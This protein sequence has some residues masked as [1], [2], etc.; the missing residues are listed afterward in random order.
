MNFSDLV[1]SLL[2]LLW[3][4]LRAEA[5]PT[6]LPAICSSC[7][8]LQESR[9]ED[10]R[11][12]RQRKVGKGE[13]EKR[14]GRNGDGKRRGERDTVNNRPERGRQDRN[15]YSSVWASV[16][17]TSLT[18]DTRYLNC[19]VHPHTHTHKPHGV[20][21]YIYIYIYTHTH[22]HTQ[23]YFHSAFILGICLV[24]LH[25]NQQ[26]QIIYET[27]TH[28][29]CVCV[30]IFLCACVIGVIISWCAYKQMCQTNKWDCW[31]SWLLRISFCAIPSVLP[32]LLHSFKSHSPRPSTFPLSPSAPTLCALKDP[33][34]ERWN[35]PLFLPL[36]LLP[37]PFLLFLLPDVREGQRESSRCPSS[38]PPLRWSKGRT[39][40]HG[41]EIVES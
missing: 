5:W 21:V 17:S 28:G 40:L 10:R 25:R 22:T 16:S 34:K 35:N 36:S 1:T 14:G 7:C 30:F 26:P 9:Y 27:T 41:I 38:S 13:I 23:K 11:E 20:C 33:E 31:I 12:E 6:F 29:V 2:Q 32:L 19:R 15:V 4:D 37:V 39:E 8:V 3:D 24:D 18:L